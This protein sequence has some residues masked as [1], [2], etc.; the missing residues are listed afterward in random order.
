MPWRLEPP[1]RTRVDNSPSGSTARIL[2]LIGLIIQIAQIVLFILGLEILASL[3]AT[4][5]V[6]LGVTSS[7]YIDG[8]AV[9]VLLNLIFTYLIYRMSYLRIAGGDFERATTPT[10]VL[11]LFAIL[12]L[13]FVSGIFYLLAWVKL[14]DA[15][16][17]YRFMS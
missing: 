9:L 15:G 8:G 5:P 10:L 4:A 7:I 14:R 1:S 16:E 2:V 6:I 17:E 12:T 11:S 13:W 3:T